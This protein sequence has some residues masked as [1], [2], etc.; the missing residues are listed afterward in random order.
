MHSLSQQVTY[1]PDN[2]GNNELYYSTIPSNVYIV[3]A[4]I[5]LCEMFQWYKLGVFASDESQYVTV[6][7]HVSC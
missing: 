6:R 5:S 1:I 7:V 4:L 3:D 2:F